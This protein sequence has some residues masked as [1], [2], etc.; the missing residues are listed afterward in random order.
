MNNSEETLSKEQQDAFEKF[1]RGNNIF[2][3][4]PGGPGKT[5]LIKNMTDWAYQNGKDHQLCSMTGCSALLLGY[6]AR[7]LHS[8]SGIKLAKGD[9]KKIINQ[10]MKNKNA[11]REWL[12]IRI[13]I[14]D[15]VSMMNK[16][17]F[18]IIEEIARGK[19][20]RAHV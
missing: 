18:D 15:E 7:T 4:G 3:T 11:K 5:K 2:L 6:G 20:G 13:L 9:P 17:I 1:K 14:V 16:K 19:I 12:R 8:W 10:A